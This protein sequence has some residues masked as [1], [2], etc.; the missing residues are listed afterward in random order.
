MNANSLVALLLLAAPAWA[1]TGGESVAPLVAQ[2][3]PGSPGKRFTAVV[4]K[5]PP[6]ARAEPH[7]HGGAFIYAYVLKGA[8]RSQVGGQ[9]V[10][11]Y[12][13]GQGW[14]EQ[15]GA[16]HLVTANASSRYPAHLLVT[17]VSNEGEPLKIIDPR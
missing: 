10:H 16:H 3:L 17:F 12:R 14:T 8:V 5:F 4:V 11:T 1:E 6:G 13:M 2:T 7:R 9:A 15:P